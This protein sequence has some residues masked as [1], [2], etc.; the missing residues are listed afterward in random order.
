MTVDITKLRILVIEDNLGDAVLL[1]EYLR[2]TEL[3]LE[4][5]VHALNLEDALK[6]AEKSEPHVIFLDLTL[7]DSQGI[8]SFT[9]I[10]QRFSHIPVIILSGTNDTALTLDAIAEGAQDYLSKNEL[11]GSMLQKSIR[12]SIE[13]KK[14]QE[15]VRLSNERFNEVSNASQDGIW[16]WNVKNN[17]FYCNDALINSFGYNKEEIMQG[18]TW[19]YANIFE[20][21]REKANSRFQ[22]ALVGD[23]K[24]WQHEY[25]FSCADGSVKHIFGRGIILRD[26]NGVA[27]RLMG[28]MQNITAMYELQETLTREKVDRQRQLAEATIEG[29]EKERAELG[30]ELH[31]NI[32]QLLAATKL[33]LSVSITKT[34]MREEMIQR[35]ISNLTHCMEEIRKLSKALVPPS[36]G[37]I[38]LD[39]ALH[40]LTEPLNFS[41][42]LKVETYVNIENSSLSLKQQI[43]VYRIVQEQLN[44]I[45][46]HSGASHAQISVVE[47]DG[48][49]DLAIADDGN[50]FDP[51]HKQDGIGLKN[52]QSRVEILQGKMEIS[53]EKGKGFI[54]KISFPAI[55]SDSILQDPG[56]QLASIH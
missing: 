4:E 40:D 28:I 47:I 55:D 27:Y 31:D 2:Q 20:E 39:D 41:G 37:L 14:S 5:L 15:S 54:L 25:R 1:E 6:S 8:E 46:K 23:A 42:T 38:N 50:G 51:N 34:E 21:D 19:W 44:N 53:S 26:S 12:Y 10:N 52:I 3:D 45:V 30:R 56:E 29:Q 24:S 16:D 36:I 13:R 33:Y 32:N 18:Y 49:I 17:D 35:S 43:N 9:R 11:S 22:K 7:P 48:H